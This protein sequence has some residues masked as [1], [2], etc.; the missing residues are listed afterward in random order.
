VSMVVGAMEGGE[1]SGRV[2]TNCVD[3]SRQRRCK[4]FR[5]WRPLGCIA[6]GSSNQA[7]GVKDVLG[8]VGSRRPVE[9]VPYRR[10]SRVGWILG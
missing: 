10:R 2:G 6:N 3:E 8:V 7:E 1:R 9:M 4:R 5:H